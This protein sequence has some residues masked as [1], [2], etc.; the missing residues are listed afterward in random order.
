MCVNE[1]TK[2]IRVAVYLRVSTDDQVERYGL[3]MQKESIMALI[4]SKG[5]LSDGRQKY[6]FAGDQY[7]YQDDGISGTTPIEE[8]PGFSRL[9]EDITNSSPENRPFDA[10]AVYKIDRFAEDLR[11]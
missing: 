2:Q 10:V 6:V 4:L 3:P 9:I 7:L 5:Q 8:R 11:Y 1:N